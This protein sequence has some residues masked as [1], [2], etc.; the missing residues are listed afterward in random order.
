MN[1]SLWIKGFKR[2]SP[3]FAYFF[4]QSV[5]LKSLNSGSAVP[6][7]NRNNVHN[8]PVGIPQETVVTAY[9]KLASPIF[10]KIQSINT[11]NQTLATLRDTLLPRLMSGELRVG[12]AKKE[13]EVSI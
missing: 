5:D 4:L 8:M 1:T 7:L 10:E 2:C 12:E 11:E 6:S 13:L 9:D 3:Y